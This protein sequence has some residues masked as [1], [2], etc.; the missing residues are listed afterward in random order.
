MANSSPAGLTGGGEIKEGQ[1]AN[2]EMVAPCD[3]EV[4]GF[5]SRDKPENS[6]KIFSQERSS[7]LLLC[8]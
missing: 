5:E 8:T 4:G 7:V 3:C 1:R 6:L 2:V